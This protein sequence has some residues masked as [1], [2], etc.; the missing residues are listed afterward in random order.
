MV[1]TLILVH[2]ERGDLHD[3]EGHLRN[4]VGFVFPLYSLPK[5][6]LVMSPI[7]DRIVMTDCGAR[8]RTSQEPVGSSLDLEIFDWNPEAIG[9]PG[10]TVLRLPRQGYY[11]KS[12]TSL[13]G[14]GVGVMTHVQGFAAFHVWRSMILIA[15]WTPMRLRLHRG[16]RFSLSDVMRL[17]Q[18]EE[19]VCDLRCA[20][21]TFDA[22]KTMAVNGAIVVARWEL[23]KEWLNH[24]TAAGI[25]NI[26]VVLSSESETWELGLRGIDHRPILRYRGCPGPGGSRFEGRGGG[27]E[28]LLGSR[29]GPGG[30]HQTTRSFIWDPEVLT[31]GPRTEI[32]ARRRCRNPEILQLDLEI[33][34]GT[35]RPCWNPEVWIRRS[36]FWNPEEPGGSSL[37]PEIFDWNPEAIG[38]PRGTVLRLPR[39]DYYRY[40]FGFR[41]LPLGSWPLSSSCA[42][43]YFYRKSLTCLEGAGVGVMTQVPGLRCFPPHRFLIQVLFTL[44][45][46]GPRCALG[47]TEVLGSFDSI[48]RLAHTHSCFMSHTGFDSLWACHCG[49]ATFMRVGQDRRSLLT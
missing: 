28:A 45:L 32:G 20:A 8:K 10:G 9:E 48:L 19:E 26:A 18:R 2:D 7:L 24:Q 11:R 47:C 25:L 29:L 41:I 12:L 33:M 3:Q 6:G 36:F 37:D 15:P 27:A 35:R 1:A 34:V 17:E 42:V 49:R 21:E 39:Q 44:V 46:L 14:Y 43:F 38:E 5:A 13:E 40:L 23:I 22:E 30:P 31:L 4:A 16:F